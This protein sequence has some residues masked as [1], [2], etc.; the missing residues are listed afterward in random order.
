MPVPISAINNKTFPSMCNYYCKSHVDIFPDNPKKHSIQEYD[1]Y[2]CASED[3]L[4]VTRGDRKP[5]REPSQHKFLGMRG[6]GGIL[7]LISTSK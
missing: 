2:A 7:V 4:H 5:D 6:G 3:R 1:Y